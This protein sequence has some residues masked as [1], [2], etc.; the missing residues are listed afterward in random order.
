M[1]VK[2]LRCIPKFITKT[3]I[4]FYT[5]DRELNI[6]ALPCHNGE[7]KPE[8]VCPM[9]I[10]QAQRINHIPFGLGHFFAFFI[11]HHGV[12]IDFPKRNLAH[13][14]DSHHDHPGNPKEND[15]KA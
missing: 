13:E 10:D 3:T 1:E 12:Q 9:G 11:S 14:M 15:I 8:G 7:S 2:K 4:S 6:S 5:V